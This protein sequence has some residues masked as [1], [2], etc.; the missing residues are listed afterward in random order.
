MRGRRTLPRSPAPLVL[1]V[2]RREMKPKRRYFFV[3]FLSVLEPRREAGFI[4]RK[5]KEMG[6]TDAHVVG[7]EPCKTKRGLVKLFEVDK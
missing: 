4:R 7:F 3:N 5:L 1:V 2:G 6:F